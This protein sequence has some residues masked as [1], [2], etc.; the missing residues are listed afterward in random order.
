M[1]TTMGELPEHWWVVAIRGAVAVVFGALAFAWPGIT[2]AVLIL[3]FGAF[4]IVSGA[5]EV[6]AGLSSGGDHR[7]WL[8]GAGLVGIIAGGVALAWP[9]VTSVVLLFIIAAWAIVSGILEIIDAIRWR[10]EME[11]E[12]LALAGGILAVLVGIALMV[13][14]ASGLLALV[15]LIGAFA[16]VYGIS[17]CVWAWQ[18]RSLEHRPRPPAPAQAPSPS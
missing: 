1:E 9:G 8:I 15:W 13:W 14:P 12:W 4:A 11:H 18:L 10:H 6:V 3:L 2:L 17:M 7:W 16:I 5:L